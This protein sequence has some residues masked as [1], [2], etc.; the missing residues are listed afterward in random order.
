[1]P[2]PCANPTRHG[3][4]IRPECGAGRTASRCARRWVYPAQRRGPRSAL[5]SRSVCRWFA[6]SRRYIGF[7]RHSARTA[8]T[9]RR[10]VFA[11]W[12][13][14]PR[15]LPVAS[16]GI[17]TK[18]AG[19]VS[20]CFSLCSIW[21]HCPC[22]SVFF[23]AVPSQRP[24]DRGDINPVAAVGTAP[25]KPR[26]HVPVHAHSMYSLHL[27]RRVPAIEHTGGCE[28]L[29]AHK[30]GLFRFS[31]TGLQRI[32]GHLCPEAFIFWSSTA[33]TP[34]PARPCPGWPPASKLRP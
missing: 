17:Q 14:G 6:M 1:M 23:I 20:A 30:S 7:A 15:P 26:C 12:T 34:R 16:L 18:K 24:P 4:H 13:C 33:E 22:Q 10:Y 32:R 2:N 11:R 8:G 5:S 21:L 19:G 3:C 31:R 27:H 25:A 28:A 9:G 29:P